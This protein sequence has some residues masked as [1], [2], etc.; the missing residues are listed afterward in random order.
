MLSIF[1]VRAN[2]G[3][4][5][6]PYAAKTVRGMGAATVAVGPSRGEMSWV[7]FPVSCDVTYT[8]T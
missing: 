2:P 3:P 1:N 5:F 4:H 8:H 6:V 7:V